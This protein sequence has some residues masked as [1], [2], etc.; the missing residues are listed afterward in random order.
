MLRTQ[1]R[2]GACQKI[3]FVA[4]L[5]VMSSA[6]VR[7]RLCS[8]V[9]AAMDNGRTIIK[10]ARV[11]DGEKIIPRATVVFSE[12]K[13]T[14][15]AESAPLPP[16]AEV[17]NGQGKTLLPGLIDSHVH[18]WS[19]ANLRQYLA[20]G[21]TAVVDMFTSPQF[22]S[23]IKKSQAEGRASDCA[24]LVSPGILATAPGGHGTQYG[25]PIPT[26]TRPDEA[27]SFV[28]ARVAEGS[29]FIKIIVDDGS[30]FG[31]SRPTLS[32]ETLAALIKAAHQ[33]GKMAIVHAATL[34]NCVDALEAGADALAHL[35]FT[36]ASD[37]DFGK[38][39][40]RQK[41][42]VIPTLSVLQTLAGIT[43]AED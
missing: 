41:A 25:L 14:S 32:K 9:D 15:V 36:D 33:R 23:E 22:M 31:L 26:L 16:D 30:A 13:I 27:E 43:E 5:I 7:G 34:Q 4:A 28:A 10:N 42:F 18:V 21:V 17:I 39:V 1:K 40:S 29:D 2:K 12:G 24:W 37:P 6:A 8:P 3:L 19:Q 38:L 35:Y 11:F 20:F